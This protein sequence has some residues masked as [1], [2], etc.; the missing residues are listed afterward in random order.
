MCRINF[1]TYK[2]KIINFVTEPVSVHNSCENLWKSSIICESNMLLNL[3]TD[4]RASSHYLEIQLVVHVLVDGPE[5]VHHLP[6]VDLPVLLL[7][8]IV[9][10]LLRHRHDQVRSG[11]LG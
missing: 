5:V 7:V 2:F 3:T 8:N 10:H 4:L 11:R 1:V 9:K 6:V